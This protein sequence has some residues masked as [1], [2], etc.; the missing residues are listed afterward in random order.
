VIRRFALLLPLLAAA[1]SHA[2]ALL[3]R[4]AFDLGCPEAD[5]VIT[6]AG[7]LHGAAGCGRRAEYRCT[8]SR[9]ETYCENAAPVPP[10][11]AD[12]DVPGGMTPQG[13]ALERARIDLACPEQRIELYTFASGGH[14]ARGCGKRVSYLC[15]QRLWRYRCAADSKVERDGG[16]ASPRW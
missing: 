13:A 16:S 3:G 1:C 11:P 5:V 9:M 14:G 2:G 10:A 4:A 12:A 15:S 6:K 7:D 8:L